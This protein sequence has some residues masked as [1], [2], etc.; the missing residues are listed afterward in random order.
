[1]AVK[2]LVYLHDFLLDIT[3][4][5]FATLSCFPSS[6]AYVW[7]WCFVISIV[8]LYNELLHN[9]HNDDEQF[10]FLL[11]FYFFPAFH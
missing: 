11:H 9:S 4:M 2:H 1:M 10:L 5:C 3:V 8:I 6:K 7:S